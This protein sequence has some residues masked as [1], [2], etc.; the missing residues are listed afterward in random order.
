LD[1]APAYKAVSYRWGD[2]LGNH[3]ILVNKL[4]LNVSDNLFDFLSRQSREA[5]WIRTPW[6]W[7][8]QLCIDQSSIEEKNHRVAR[9][10]FIYSK[11]L[12]VLVWLGKGTDGTEEAVRVAAR[13][14]VR[15]QGTDR[16]NS[17]LQ[18]FQKIVSNQYWSRLWIIQEFV[19]A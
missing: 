19:L 16:E 9:M 4:L 6:I 15:R 5:Q 8:D 11:A 7:I 2:S 3:E 12:Q 10:G 17:E 18:A 14:A 1:S 13:N